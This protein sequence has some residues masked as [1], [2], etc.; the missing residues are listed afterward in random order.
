MN[1]FLMKSKHGKKRTWRV[2]RGQW[3]AKLHRWTYVEFIGPDDDLI[4]WIKEKTAKG[5]M[6]VREANEIL[7]T[8]EKYPDVTYIGLS[9]SWNEYDRE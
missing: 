5:I 6:S 1:T 7:K 9:P 2:C 3:L 8:L 4:A